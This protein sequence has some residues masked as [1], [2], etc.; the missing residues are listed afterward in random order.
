T[1]RTRGIIVNSPGN[2]TGALIS[3]GALRTLGEF[4]AKNNIWLVVD[5]CYEKLIYDAVP[6]NLP[7]VL[8]EKC[9][10]LTVLC[11]SASKAYAMTGWRCGWALGPAPVVAAAGAIQS[12]A[13]SNVTS[14][15][16]KA[17]VEA[18][19]G[20][21]ATVTEMLD[22]YRR[23]RDALHE[24]LSADSR[25]RCR[26]PAGAFYMFVDI[27]DVLSGIDPGGF[28]TSLDFADALL[29]ES[30]VALT[31]GEA[32]D[33]PGFIRI[34]YATSMENLREGSKRLLEFVAK[35]APQTT[36]AR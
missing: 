29:E 4:A 33:A 36:T 32:F 11:G 35:H 22:E 34:S 1:P 3:E 14:I 30:R 6:H 19:N 10:D 25:L 28:R 5:L 15:T 7:R 18:L 23:R 9:R 8:A 24:W 21:Q 27:S 16:Q 13:T 26:K 2:P 17:A 31:P 20:P 12:H